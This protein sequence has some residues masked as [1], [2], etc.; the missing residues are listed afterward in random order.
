MLC[1]V[2]L[3]FACCTA[4]GCE[5][6][7][8]TTSAYDHRSIS[9]LPNTSQ[10]RYIE[11]DITPYELPFWEECFETPPAPLG[12]A[13]KAEFLKTLQGVALSSDAFFPFRCEQYS[14]VG[15]VGVVFGCVAGAVQCD[16][17]AILRAF[18]ISF[19]KCM[20]T[21]CAVLWVGSGV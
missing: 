12:E 6:D 14:F 15:W 13:E 21:V 4:G 20:Q 3:L 10:V 19:Y 16:V 5:I 11:G 17:Y 8:S 7:V 2:V 18:L 1:C 9:L